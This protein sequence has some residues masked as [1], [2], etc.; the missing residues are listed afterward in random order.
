MWLRLYQ[1]QMGIWFPRP[2]AA[3]AVDA[4]PPV[5]P[6]DLSRSPSHVRAGRCHRGQRGDAPFAAAHC[7]RLVPVSRCSC[8]SE[9]STSSRSRCG[10]D[11]RAPHR[12]RSTCTPT[13][14]SN[15]G[16]RTDSPDRHP[17]RQIQ[18]A[19]PGPRIP[20]RTLTPGTDGALTGPGSR[21][22]YWAACET[23]DAVAVE[24]C[25]RRCTVTLEP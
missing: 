10:W 2:A 9:T 18:A 12:P 14:D 6:A 13:T 24:T 23:G 21:S 22:R 7:P 8:A 25:V 3:I 15:A 17:A 4:A 1:A 19:R 16:D 20:R 11:T 5:P